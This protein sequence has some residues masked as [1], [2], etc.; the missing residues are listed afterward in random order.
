MLPESQ[1]GALTGGLGV[2]PAYAALVAEA[3]IDAAVRSGM[4]EPVAARL[5]GASMAGGAAMLRA[6]EW[7]RSACGAR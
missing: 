6:R 3:Q 5:V 4:P 2:A 7:T 1:F